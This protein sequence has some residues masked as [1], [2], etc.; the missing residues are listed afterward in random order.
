MIEF[1][2]L[3]PRQ[4][5]QSLRCGLFLRF[6]MGKSHSRDKRCP[7]GCLQQWHEDHQAKNK[8]RA[9]EFLR[10][11]ETLPRDMVSPHHKVHRKTTK[12]NA[13]CRRMVCAQS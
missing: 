8:F 3:P 11:A 1:G 6:M 9:T 2:T 5:R 4:F 13:G 7:Q 10:F 12:G